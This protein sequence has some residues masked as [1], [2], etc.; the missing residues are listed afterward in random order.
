[1]QSPDRTA[2]AYNQFL[3]AHLLEDASDV[4]GAIAAYKR[5]MQSDPTASDIAADLASLYLKENRSNEAMAAAEQALKI[6]PTNREAHRVLGTLYASTAGRASDRPRAARDATQQTL[7]RA[8]EHLEKAVEGS[9]ASA[10]PN[11]RVMLAQVYMA[12]ASYDKAIPIL[13]D[14]VK[15]EP[16]W[17]QGPSLLVEAYSAAGR[18]ADAVVWLEEASQGNPQLYTM[19]ADFYGRERRWADS[20]NAYEQALRRSPRSFDLRVRL[21][22]SLLN[23]GNRADVLKARDALREAVAMRATDE[24]ALYLLS[25]AER[26]AGEREA[27]EAT[28]RR[29]IA[30]NSKNPRGYFALAEALE[31]QRRIQP[32]IDVLEP[33]VATFRSAADGVNALAMLLPHLGFAYQELGQHD[34][35][36]AAFEEARKAAP[37]DPALAG[38]VIQAHLAAK[39][40]AAA[41]D[42]AHAARARNPSDLR[43]VRLEAQ[44]LRRGGKAAQALAL[45]EEVVRTQNTNPDAYV[46]L[47][48][49]YVDANR[50]PQAVKLLQEAQAKFPTETSITFQLGAAFDKQKRFAEA[51]A[52]FRQLIGKEPDNAQALNYLG[53]MLA[54]RG[55]RLDESVQYL[56]R[57]LVIDPE[58]GSYLDSIGW[59]YYKDGK[60]DLALDNLKRAAERLTANSVVQS[61]YGEVLFKLG[62]FDEAIAAWNRALTGDGDEIDRGDID[63]KIRTARQKLPRK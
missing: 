56:K 40:Y 60:L 43:L 26:R 39:N 8:I 50:H 31:E 63:K 48:Q 11:L 25:Q 9:V 29:L 4:E 49:G 19:L 23:T 24:R 10:D 38:Y 5:A 27:A 62:K 53:Y 2:E 55:E 57:A 6:S 32:L 35:A 59:A 16:G 61:H 34:K 37:D 46:M 18:G 15:Q 47:A 36:I 21:A 52:Q 58:N 28:A 51:E 12:S 30:Q 1:V 22:S 3:R 17:Q 42:L 20:A 33:A 41:A 54:E 45:L 14:L 7:A 44:A 13:V